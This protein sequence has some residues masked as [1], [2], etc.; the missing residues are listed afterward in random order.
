MMKGCLVNSPWEEKMIE[1][2]NYKTQWVTGLSLMIA[3]LCCEMLAFILGLTMFNSNSALL[4]IGGHSLACIFL[5][6]LVLNG[7][8]CGWF[9]WIFSFGAVLP[10]IH[11]TII[12]FDTLINKK[13]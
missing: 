10:F 6:G 8:Q 2:S 3:F 5:A 7:W 4:S 9:W 11:D 1:I 13:Y 12:T